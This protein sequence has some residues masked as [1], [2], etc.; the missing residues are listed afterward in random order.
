MGDAHDLINVTVLI[1]GKPE[2]RSLDGRSTVAQ[3][4]GELLPEFEKARAA[5]YA[6]YP[7]DGPPLEHASRLGG[8]DIPDGSVLVLVKTDGGG[9]ACGRGDC[10]S[11][12][13]L[14]RA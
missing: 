9:G 12:E 11:S 14:V 4:V 8:N 7:E 6:L 3:I 13:V 10:R 5:D 2:E 1:D